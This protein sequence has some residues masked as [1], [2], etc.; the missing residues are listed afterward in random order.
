MNDDNCARWYREPIMLIVV[1]VLLF[2]LTSG[3]A[4]LT[5]SLT[6]RDALVMTDEAYQQ[7]RDEMRATAPPVADD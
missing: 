5:F 1:G 3:T 7:W 4:M 6:H 2:T